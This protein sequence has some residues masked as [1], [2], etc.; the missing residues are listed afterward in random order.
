VATLAAKGIVPLDPV[1][2]EAI[3]KVGNDMAASGLRVLGFAYK[4]LAA[5]SP[6]LSPELLESELIFAGLVGIMDPPRPE[7]AEAI[8]RCHEAGIR[9]DD[10]GD[11]RLT[12]TAI[13]QRS[14]SSKRRA[15]GR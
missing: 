4:E 14:G 3:L 8:Q 10:H 6:A 1:Q 11:H 5:V 15:P 12:A 13:G 7:V 9:V 2:R